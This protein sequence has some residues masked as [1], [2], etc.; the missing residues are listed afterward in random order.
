M[1]KQTETEESDLSAVSSFP[2]DYF[3]TLIPFNNKSVPI[4]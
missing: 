2:C 4:V 3:G 1:I